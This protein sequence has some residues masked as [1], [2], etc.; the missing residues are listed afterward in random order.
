MASGQFLPERGWE[1]VSPPTLVALMG[2]GRSVALR[3]R[4]PEVS[5]LAVRCPRSPRRSPNRRREE[6]ICFGPASIQTPANGRK[7]EGACA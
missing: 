3:P 6:N 2:E 7:H 1:A 4:A 5:H